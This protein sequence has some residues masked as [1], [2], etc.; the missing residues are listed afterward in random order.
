MA[1]NANMLIIIPSGILVD[2]GTSFSG[3]GGGTDMGGGGRCMY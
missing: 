1:V 2:I 3:L